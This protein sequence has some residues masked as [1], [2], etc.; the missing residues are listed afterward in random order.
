MCTKT[1]TIS[2]RNKAK[3]FFFMLFFNLCL[4]SM[5]SSRM[6]ADLVNIM[7]MLEND[8]P[9]LNHL[10]QWWIFMHKV[11]DTVMMG[12]HPEITAGFELMFTGFPRKFQYGGKTKI[13]TCMDFFCDNQEGDY[14]SW[15]TDHLWL[16]KHNMKILHLELFRTCS[17]VLWQYFE[18]HKDLVLRH[19]K[20]KLS[21]IKSWHY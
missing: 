21:Q 8:I 4:I 9:S 12:S 2:A 5:L 16:Q 6:T 19:V 15:H 14:W 10:T 20:H 1:V 11:S 17:E 13:N 3:V 18:K 7:I